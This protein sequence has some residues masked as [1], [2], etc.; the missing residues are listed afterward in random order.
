[1]IGL[2]LQGGGAKGG[3]HI[4]VWK[5]LRELNIK[6]GAVT[7]TSVG[8]LN[9]AFIAQ[10]KY[11]EAYEIWYNMDP[12]LIFKDNPE[13][14]HQLVTKNINIYDHK[15]YYN[16]LKKITKQKGLD[17]GPLKELIKQHVDESVLRT[18]AIDFGL[19]TVSLTD[20]KAVEIF[21]EDMEQ[22][23]V[24]DYL[25]ASAFL[26]GFKPQML[27]G[28]RYLDGG[29]HDNLP[30]NLISQKGFDEII[31]V[32]LNAVGINRHVKDK[33]LNIRRI[34]PSSDTGSLLEFDQKRSRQNIKMG[35]LD[36]LRFY[37]LYEGF[38]YYLTDVPEDE[39]FYND[40]LALTDEQIL[41]MAKIIGIEEGYPFRLL[42]EVIIPELCDM[43]GFGLNMTYK[44]ILIGV[45]EFIATAIGMER[46]KVYEYNEFVDCIM[47]RCQRPS[48]KIFNFEDV[49][50][51]FRKSSL[52]I[53]SFRVD[54]LIRWLE[55]IGE[56][57]QLEKEH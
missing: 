12:R 26:P 23:T 46:L 38:S 35:Y 13:V 55:I 29:F 24:K 9:G 2:V 49:P 5:A 7:G 45:L 47:E 15:M 36:T 25:L 54:L 37:G 6:I 43:L 27:H 18:S 41:S 22:G 50:K 42:T 28:K 44:D 34:I 51:V 33:E 3:Y 14:Y 39:F 16:F 1:M 11:E 30:I 17:I 21:V 10:N 48:T 19:V 53:K 32:E 4:G 40:L 56:R 8:A 57:D 52:V 20:W 31:A